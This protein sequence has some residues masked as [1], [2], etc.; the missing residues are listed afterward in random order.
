MLE[1]IQHDRNL[2][3][4]DFKMDLNYSPRLKIINI[5]LLNLKIL[6]LKERLIMLDSHLFKNHLE[7]IF[8]VSHQLIHHSSLLFE[9]FFKVSKRELK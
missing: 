3:R 9:A 6:S 5:Q 7:S 2:L 8:M 1:T 4:R